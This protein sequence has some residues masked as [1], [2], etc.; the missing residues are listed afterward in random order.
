MLQLNILAE[1]NE[2]NWQYTARKQ[3]DA[4]ATAALSANPNERKTICLSRIDLLESKYSFLFLVNRSTEVLG[5]FIES[6]FV[7][8]QIQCDDDEPE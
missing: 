6:D 5:D 8:L 4:F 3:C 1:E 7:L 2:E